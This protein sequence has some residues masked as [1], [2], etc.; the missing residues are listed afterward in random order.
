[1]MENIRVAVLIKLALSLLMPC[2]TICSSTVVKF[3]LMIPNREPTGIVPAVNQVLDE[4]NRNVSFLPDH[5]LEYMLRE[6]EVLILCKCYI[7]LCIV[8]FSAMEP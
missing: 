4:I 6:I 5:R 7:K 2:P 8:L 1:M 3:L